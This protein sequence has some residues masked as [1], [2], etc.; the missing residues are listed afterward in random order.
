MVKKCHQ[1]LR[2]SLEDYNKIAKNNKLEIVAIGDEIKGVC[3]K[4]SVV[5][6][7]DNVHS[8][9]TKKRIIRIKETEGDKPNIIINVKKNFTKKRYYKCRGRPASIPEYL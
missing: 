1:K 3:E 6:I 7:G 5:N 2:S 4:R 9:D 8:K